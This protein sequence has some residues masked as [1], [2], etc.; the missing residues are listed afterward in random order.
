VFLLKVSPHKPPRKFSIWPADWESAF[1]HSAT[2]PIGQN[3]S[4]Q[5]DPAKGAHVTEWV[6]R[7]KADNQD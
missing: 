7:G 5:S 4:Q 3:N 2:S 6:R 1:N